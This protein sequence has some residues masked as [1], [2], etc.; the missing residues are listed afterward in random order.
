MKAYAALIALDLRL[1]LR[2]RSVLF[3][4]YLFPVVF[5]AVFA[6][7][8]H[9]D[10]S[11]GMAQIV[12]MVTILGVLNNG[13]VGAGMRAVQEREAN[14]LRRYKVTPITAAPLL[15]ASTIVGW[16]LFMPLVIVLFALAHYAYGM[17]RPMRLGGIFCFITLGI[18]A[19]RA[20]G[21]ILAA[22]A[23]ST[24]E[25]QIMVQ[26]IYL[27]MLFLSGATL[28]VAMFPYWLQVAAQF[29]PATHLVSGIQRMMLRQ[30]TLSMQR[31]A[32]I[33]LATT[34]AVGLFVSY[35]RFRWE[36]EEKIRASAKLWIV[37]VLL[38]FVVLGTWRA[39]FSSH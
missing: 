24:Q 7:V 21:M 3:Y 39:F 15:V 5:F 22:V 33:A 31:E 18:V 27:P 36:K 23:N 25:S 34:T 16:I 20:I 26:F 10:Q 17:L 9:H 30:E 35:K 2:Q 1:A 28:P 8:S 32:I 11:L 6:E 14:I 4:N 13:L 38:P 29:L 12:V 37:A 19:F